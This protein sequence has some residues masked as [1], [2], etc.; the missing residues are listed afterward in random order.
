MACAV[1]GVGIVLSIRPLSQNASRSSGHVCHGVTIATRRYCGQMLY[2]G[3]YCRWRTIMNT[4]VPASGQGSRRG[5][6]PL[7]ATAAVSVILLSAV[8]VAALVG[9]MPTPWAESYGEQP[10]RSEERRVGQEGV[11]KCRSLGLWDNNKKT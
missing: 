9:W 1:S 10:V 8:A 6:H 11:W 7:V 2:N 4:P 5:L 3:P